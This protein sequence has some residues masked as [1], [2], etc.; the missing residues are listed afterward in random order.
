M[1]NTTAYVNGNPEHPHA[2][3]VVFLRGG[4]DGLNMVVPVEDDAYYR[5]RPIIGIAKKDTIALDGFFGLHPALAP[6]HEAYAAGD[7][8]IVHGAGSEDQ[9]RS[10]F[11][12]QDSM[13]H[14][15]NAGGGWLGRYLRFSPRTI[16][17]PLSAVALG[18]AKPLCL[19]GAPGTVTMESFDQF[20]LGDTPPNFAPELAALYSREH[21]ALGNAGNDA[22]RAMARI[23]TLRTQE[24]VPAS[25][26]TY[27]D[28]AFGL[29]MRQ[30]AQMLK[31]RVG[32][33]AA[34]IDL[35]GWDSHF[36]TST[37]MDPL[38]R[39][40][41][42][43]I[44][45]FHKDLGS[46]MKNVTLVVM[47]EFGRR[48][49]ENVSFGTDHGRG[50]VMFVL[51]GG[52]AGGKVHHQWKGLESDRLDG[53]GDLPVRYNYRDVLA[54]ILQR[55]GGITDMTQVFP[56]YDVEPLPLYA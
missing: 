26:A 12:A 43:G 1:A 27:P 29:G 11:E 19:W 52:V 42:G 55:H 13:E 36:A 22:F 3:I 16:G 21:N 15:G 44:A 10:H 33:E 6:L 25:G 14:G 20:A 2:L 46:R 41:A 50:G 23:E 34:F 45:A 7:L 51:G 31:A 37:L 48:V 32:L 17:G 38:M 9:T 49:Y 35:G 47:S 8:S 24:Y 18:K 4:A 28:G 53:P 54:P 56:E 39:Q 40:L 30:I 5:A